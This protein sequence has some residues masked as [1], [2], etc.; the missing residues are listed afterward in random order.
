MFFSTIL[1]YYHIDQ[2]YWWRKPLTDRLCKLG[3]FW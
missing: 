3:I 1:T 2:F